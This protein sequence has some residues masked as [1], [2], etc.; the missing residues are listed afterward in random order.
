MG[1]SGYKPGTFLTGIGGQWTVE[2]CSKEHLDRAPVKGNFRQRMA[3]KVCAFPG[4]KSG[5]RGTRRSRDAKSA[6]GWF[7]GVLGAKIKGKPVDFGFDRR[8][9]LAVH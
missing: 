2:A 8:G 1:L 4:P 9:I 5:T 6:S 7:R 3:G